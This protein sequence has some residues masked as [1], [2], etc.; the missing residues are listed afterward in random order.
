MARPNPPRPLTRRG[1]RSAVMP[2]KS[3]ISAG[4]A[5]VSPRFQAKVS[6]LGGTGAQQHRLQGGGRAAAHGQQDVAVEQGVE[7]VVVH[8]GVIRLGDGLPGDIRRA[9]Q[10]AGIDHGD[11]AHA[12]AGGFELILGLEHGQK[13]HVAGD[14]EDHRFFLAAFVRPVLVS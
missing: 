12:I 1:I 5:V 4:L 6:R 9:I 10:A 3:M 11:D 7:M 8:E 2:L 13:D 14:G